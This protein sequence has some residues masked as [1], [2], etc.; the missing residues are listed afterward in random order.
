MKPDIQIYCV[1]SEEKCPFFETNTWCSEPDK[2]HFCIYLGEPYYFDS[3]NRR[4]CL[5]DFDLKISTPEKQ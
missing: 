4:P 5:K 2:E 3:M 1:Y